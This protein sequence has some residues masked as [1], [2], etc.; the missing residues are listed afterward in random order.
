MAGVRLLVAAVLVVAGGTWVAP[1]VV[2]APPPGATAVCRDGTYSF[3]QSRSGTCS[4]HGGVA[5]WLAGTSA[6]P[7]PTTATAPATSP[8]APSSG[9][10]AWIRTARVELARLP[11]RAAATMLGYRRSRFGP[12][13]A[14]VNDNGCDTRNDILRRDLVNIVLRRGSRCVVLSGILHDPYT[15]RTIRFVRGV[16][17]SLAVQIDHVVAL[18]DAWRTGA[19]RWTASKRL[20]YANDPLVLLAVDG[21]SNGAKGDRDASQWLP[22]RRAFGCRYVARQITIKTKYGLWVTSP[23]DRAMARVLALWPRC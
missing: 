22:P 1:R 6:P 12:T 17:T 3:S 23:E 18:A 8:S 15:G 21:P 11:V 14:D 20:R 2:A 4:R 7:R 5:R 19:A 10:P 9:V 13:W 16:G